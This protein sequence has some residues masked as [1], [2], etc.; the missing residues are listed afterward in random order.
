MWRAMVFNATQVTGQLWPVAAA[1][2]PSAKLF[3]M[4]QNFFH[5]CC[6]QAVN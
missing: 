4:T 5:I 1:I 3:A 6:D 2:Q